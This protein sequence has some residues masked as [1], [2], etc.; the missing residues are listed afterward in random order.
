MFDPSTRVLIVDDMSMMRKVILKVVKTLG[1]EDIT[2]AQDG[3]AAWEEL[4]KAAPVAPFGLVISDWV[5]PNCTGLDLLKKIRA[6]EKFKSIPVVMITAEAEQHQI[7]EAVKAGVNSY[8]IKPFTSEDLRQKL[9]GVH[10]K[11]A[12]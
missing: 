12:G 6:D 10:K 4:Q 9:E 2:E 7:I 8:I 5:M 3:N 11:I 1:F